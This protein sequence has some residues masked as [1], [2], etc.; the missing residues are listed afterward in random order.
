VRTSPPRQPDAGDDLVVE[1]DV[2]V[3]PGTEGDRLV[4]EWFARLLA[5]DADPGVGSAE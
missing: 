4:V 3:G 1:L 2:V 5:G